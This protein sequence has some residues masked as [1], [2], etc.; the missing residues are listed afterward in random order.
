MGWLPPSRLKSK[1]GWAVAA[2][3]PFPNTAAGPC[4]S[5]GGLVSLF[6]SQKPKGPSGPR[7]SP[8]KGLL[9]QGSRPCGQGPQ[10][11]AIRAKG[12]G[13]GPRA[14]PPKGFRAKGPRPPNPS[15]GP[16]A[17]DRVC[18]CFLGSSQGTPKGQGTRTDPSPPS[19]PRP[20]E[21]PRA[22]K[23]LQKLQRPTKRRVS[24]HKICPCPQ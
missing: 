13:P 1:G 7:A 10:K 23:R 21:A 15:P 16:R 2:A 4:W 17:L 9:G 14:P 6:E 20:Q 8:A 11:R 18:L 22:T 19:R 24:D 12:K 3:F 5:R